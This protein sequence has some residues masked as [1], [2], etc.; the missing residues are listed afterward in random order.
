MKKATIYI[1][2]DGKEFKSEN[3][4][5]AY[6]LTIAAQKM[7][8]EDRLNFFLAAALNARAINLFD[9]PSGEGVPPGLLD[10][11]DRI[12]FDEQ[13]RLLLSER[14]IDTWLIVKHLESFADLGQLIV[15]LR[16]DRRDLI[17]EYETP[18]ASPRTN[19]STSFPDLSATFDH[20]FDDEFRG[21]CG[22]LN[23]RIPDSHEGSPY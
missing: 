5:V 20:E 22:D 7:A 19:C 16:S 23:Y 13:F 12:G 1:A 6:E 2:D 14:N 17:L 9:G 10:D 3:E 15:N 18:K 21:G 8:L 11:S 4:C